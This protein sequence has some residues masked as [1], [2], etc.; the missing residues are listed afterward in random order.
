MLHEYNFIVYIK[1]E[2]INTDIKKE[3]ETKFVA[4]LRAK[5]YSY[6]TDNNNEDKKSKRHKKVYR[7]IKNKLNLKI[8]KTV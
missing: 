2:D 1:T 6:L 5:T 7:E 4:A 3:V 8:I